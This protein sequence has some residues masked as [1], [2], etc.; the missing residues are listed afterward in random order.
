MAS[1]LTN[2]KTSLAGIAAV[3]TALSAVATQAASGTIDTATIINSITALAAG[4]GLLAAKDGTT[5]S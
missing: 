3:L 1:F 2:W 5:K 4:F